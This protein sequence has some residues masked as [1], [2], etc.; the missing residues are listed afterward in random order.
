MALRVSLLTLFTQTI[1]YTGATGSLYILSA[2]MIAAAIGVISSY[3]LFRQG[4]EKQAD[5]TMAKSAH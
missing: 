5:V 1:V 4:G 2:L 3:K